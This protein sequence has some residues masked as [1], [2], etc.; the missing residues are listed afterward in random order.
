M[1]RPP[2]A[3][4]DVGDVAVVV[5]HA[6]AAVAA[7]VS[8]IPDRPANARVRSYPAIFCGGQQ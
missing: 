8:T 6:D 5:A 2:F 7:D 3:A 1:A 4:S